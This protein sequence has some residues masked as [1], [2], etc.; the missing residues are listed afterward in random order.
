MLR[1]CSYGE[2]DYLIYGDESQDSRKE[3]VIAIAGLLGDG[4]QWTA[5]KDAWATRTG[6]TRFHAA[7]C[8]S[9]YGEY[10][11]VAPEERSALIVDLA[12]L[13]ADSGLIGWGVGIDLAGC[14][15]AFPEMMSDQTYC[16]AFLRTIDF[17]IER[18]RSSNTSG[19]I[20]I[21]FDQ[22]RPTEHNTGL[23]Y[24]YASAE[25]GWHEQGLLPE[26]LRF[27]SRADI[28]IQAADLWVRELMKFFDGNLFTEG[29]VPRPQWQ[30]LIETRRFGGNLQCA[31]YFEDMRQKLPLL[32]AQV[33]MSR[34]EYASWLQSKRHH[35]NQSNRI[36]YMMEVAARD[37]RAERDNRTG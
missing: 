36:T 21:I 29:Y 12:K 20:E 37:R 18:A 8:E 34:L 5:L 3:R 9:G 26:Q 10:R 30:T 6:G 1:E 22:H 15:R 4:G 13:L 14:R 2:P 35:D 28:G 33:G 24:K 23:L 16:S 32:E 11:G 25:R 17:L 7:D 19:A 31:E 27:A